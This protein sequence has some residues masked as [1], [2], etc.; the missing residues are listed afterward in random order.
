[1][2]IRRMACWSVKDA[3]FGEF[4]QTVRHERIAAAAGQSK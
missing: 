4:W 1:M 3:E 2:S